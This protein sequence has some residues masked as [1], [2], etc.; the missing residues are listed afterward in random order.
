[1]A[2]EGGFETY[3]AVRGGMSFCT[4]IAWRLFRDEEIIFYSRS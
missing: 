4:F 1:M 3:G 2:A